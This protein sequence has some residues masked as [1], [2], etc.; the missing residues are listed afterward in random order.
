MVDIYR[1]KGLD[2]YERVH[3]SRNEHIEEVEEIL[4]WYDGGRRLLDAGCSG[5]LHAVEFARRGYRVTG[6]DIEPSA[7]ARAVRR[8][9]AAQAPARFLVLDIAREELGPL[10]PFDLAYSLGNVLSHIP[11]ELVP[12]V[13]R[14]FRACLTPGG[15]FLFDLLIKGRPFREHIWDEYYRI[16]WTRSLDEASGRVRMDGYFLDFEVVQ[17][18]EVWAYSPEEVPGLLRDAGFSP[19]G[20]DESLD[21]TNGAAPGANPFCLNF[22]ARV[23]EDP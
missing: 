4:S 19:E 13:L 23:E 15:L 12:D 17:P 11:R 14:R 6:V 2:V 8:A 16:H 1:G 18:F 3:Y 5:G 22:R 9:A 7:V 21:F 20:V 10:G